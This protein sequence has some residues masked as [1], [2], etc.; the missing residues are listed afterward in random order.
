[1][2]FEKI[3]KKVKKNV[4]KAV[5]TTVKTSNDFIDYSKCKVKISSLKDNI[6]ENFIKIG[7]MVY[8]KNV[9]DIDFDDSKMEKLL[10]E[11]SEWN[12]E[13]DKLNDVIN[14]KN[15]NDFKNSQNDDDETDENDFEL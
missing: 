15:D 7:E 1:M 2:D 14:K 9:N 12:A 5:K 6:E 8:N 4:K 3:V 11:I 10:N 13:I